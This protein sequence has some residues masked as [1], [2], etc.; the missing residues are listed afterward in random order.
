MLHEI[1][2]FP[3]SSVGKQSACNAGNPGSGWSAR[4]GK[5]YPF[6]F[7]GL[8]ISMDCI[9]YGVA[10]S[11]TWLSDSLSLYFSL[12]SS[13]TTSRVMT[14]PS[15]QLNPIIKPKRNC[16]CPVFVHPTPLIPHASSSSWKPQQA[17]F[18]PSSEQPG[19]IHAFLILLC[20]TVICVN[21]FSLRWLRVLWTMIWYHILLPLLLCGMLAHMYWVGY[22]V[23]SGFSC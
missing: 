15:F 19:S 23:H 12:R 5:G 8:E 3:D 22:K 7:S 4:E 21:F 17:M 14:F 2:N 11:Q 10:K 16:H 13:V 18:S 1:L 20:A 9:V 6:Q